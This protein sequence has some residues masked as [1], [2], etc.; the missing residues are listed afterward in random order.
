MKCTHSGKRR[1]PSVPDDSNEE[2]DDD[3]YEQLLNLR[4][5]IVDESDQIPHTSSDFLDDDYAKHVSAKDIK[6]ILLG[7]HQ[8][9][10]EDIL[11]SFLCSANG[12]KWNSYSCRELYEFAFSSIHN[13]Y[14]AMTSYDLDIVINV[15]RKWECKDFPLGMK[16]NEPKVKKINQLGFIFANTDYISPRKP[17]PK[18]KPLVELCLHEAKNFVPT[19]VLRVALATFDFWIKLP[20]W[21]DKLTVPITYEIPVESHTFDVF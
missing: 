12:M 21:M 2:F 11:I 14:A 1:I 9:I 13:M 6:N 7:S 18:M 3:N 8:F 15:L 17:V 20:L 5:D 4:A 19:S 10:L 16:L